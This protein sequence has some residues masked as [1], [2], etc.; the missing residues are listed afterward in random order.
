MALFVA[1]RHFSCEFTLKHCGAK[2][3]NW[4]VCDGKWQTVYEGIVRL[5]LYLLCLAANVFVF[6]SFIHRSLT[7][8]AKMQHV[9][10]LKNIIIWHTDYMYVVFSS[11]LKTSS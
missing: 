8:L 10:D 5:D 9:H 6:F 4:C 1:G 7:I 11:Y 2:D 3:N